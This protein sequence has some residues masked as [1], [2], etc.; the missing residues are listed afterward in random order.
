MTFEPAFTG[1]ACS[2]GYVAVDWIEAHCCHG[3]G[4]IM[5][6]PAHVDDEMMDF[7][8]SAY[9]LDPRTGRR[10]RAEGVLSRAKGRAK[11]EVAAWLCCFEALGPCRFDHFDADGQ[12][13][14]KPMTAPLI[15]VLATEEGQTGNTFST[16]AFICSEWGPENRPDVYAGLTGV[17]Q[18]QSASAVYLPGGGEIRACTAGAASKD[19]GKETFVVADE[20]HLYVTRELRSMY[21]TVSRNLPKRKEAQPWLLQTTTA[22]APGE[23]SIAEQ[24]LTS[25]RKRELGEAV[26]VDHVEARGAVRIHDK[27][28]TLA[29]LRQ[30]YKAAGDWID[31]EGI[32]GK[33]LD[34]R[35]CPD[36][37]TAARYY[38]NRAMSGAD[39]WIAKDVHERQTADGRSGRPT[40]IVEVGES[41]CLGFDGSLN[42]DTT[43][44]RGSCMSDGFL[45]RIGAWPKPSGAAGIGWQVPRADVLA[46]IREAFDLYDVV[47]MY[48]DPHEWRSDLDDL[49]GEFG[50][51]RVIQWPTTLDSQMGAALDRLHTG[52][53]NGT[54]WHDADALAAE[55]YGNVY[56]RRKGPHRLVRKENPNSA[57]K[58]DSVVGDALALRARSDALAAGWTA[59]A[60]DSQV[61][62]WT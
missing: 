26:L 2:L 4:D 31:F 57:R 62:C 24:T 7:I 49:A 43:V 38:L 25:W 23:E 35:V 42:D 3:E 6:R 21:A 20:T 58:I 30:V 11:S 56:L 32:Y 52:L 13:V 50:E 60:A 1:Q 14:G 12:P 17:R 55:H 8:I 44:L 10:L 16:V 41:V 59:G 61:I 40:R 34:P 27:D 48:A 18:Y 53:V 29:Q 9:E 37:A 15:K 28:H 5:G 33:M 45:F 39:A 51:E 36:D 22:Y 47:R 46:S 19:G 54:L